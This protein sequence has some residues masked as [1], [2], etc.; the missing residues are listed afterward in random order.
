MTIQGLLQNILIQIHNGNNVY[1]IANFFV[2]RKLL[3]IH[4]H[5]LT[6]NCN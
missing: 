3:N 2:E 4:L 6:T 1:V 5:V